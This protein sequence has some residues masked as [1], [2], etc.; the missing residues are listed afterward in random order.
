MD[1]DVIPMTEVTAIGDKLDSFLDL[2]SSKQDV[3]IIKLTQPLERLPEYP[4]KFRI[5]SFDLEVRNPHGMPN[6]E[7]DEIIMIGVSSNFGI[8]QVISTKTNSPD[9]DDFVNQ[10]ESERAMIEEFVNI[11]GIPL[12][13]IDTAGIRKTDDKI[14]EIGATL[15]ARIA[16]PYLTTATTLVGY[17]GATALSKNA[18]GEGFG[19]YYATLPFNEYFKTRSV[20]IRE[21]IKAL[22]AECGVYPDA[23][24]EKQDAI[25]EVTT[26]VFN[27][28]GDGKRA[29]AVMNDSQEVAEDILVLPAGDYFDID[30]T[31]RTGESVGDKIKFKV[32]LAPMATEVFMQK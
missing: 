7:E 6:S 31:P 19:Y 26:F 22:L 11:R 29:F 17:N 18:F 13:I 21:H 2:D 30:G 12:R 10:V 5:L 15:G 32:T 23:S 25:P 14:E 16:E 4:Q 3:E 24:L 27:I 1:R 28:E 20:K 9:R 8:N